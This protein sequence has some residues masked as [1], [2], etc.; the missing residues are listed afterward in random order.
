MFTLSTCRVDITLQ[1]CNNRYIRDVFEREIAL[2]YQ[3]VET[4]VIFIR[5]ILLKLHKTYFASLALYTHSQITKMEQIKVA[6]LGLATFKNQITGTYCGSPW[7]MA[8]EIS[9]ENR[10]YD[11]KVDMHSFGLMMWEMWF[12]EIVR[13]EPIS[14]SEDEVTRQIN[15]RKQRAEGRGGTRH[16]PPTKWIELMVCLWNAE[17]CVRKTAMESKELMKEVKQS[18]NEEKRF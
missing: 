6:D 2:S 7:Y 14:C 11:S 13:P 5:F 4:Y 15:E 18:L 1:E 8:P 16:P 9:R 17:P 12:G 10:I 3:T